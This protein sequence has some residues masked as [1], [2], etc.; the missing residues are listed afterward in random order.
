MTKVLV[1]G[2]LRNNEYNFNSFQRRYGEEGVKYLE[3]GVIK[4][5]ELYSFGSFPGI[6]YTGNEED[7]LTVDLLEVSEEAKQGMDWMELGAGYKI[8]QVEFNGELVDIYEYGSDTIRGNYEQV[9]HGD[10]SLYLKE[11][12][13]EKVG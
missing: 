2:S 7:E 13:Y 9:K 3:T 12:R 5:F 1:Y 8:R 4:G 6:L 10:W 11:R